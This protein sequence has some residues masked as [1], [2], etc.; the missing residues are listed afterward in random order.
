MNKV[1]KTFDKALMTWHFDTN[2]KSNEKIEEYGV[3]HLFIFVKYILVY[4]YKKPKIRKE[5]S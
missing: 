4:R 2:L 5:H 3:F 1:L